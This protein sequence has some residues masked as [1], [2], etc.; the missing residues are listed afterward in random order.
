[1]IDAAE[2]VKKED[3]LLQIKRNREQEEKQKRLDEKRAAR[4]KEVEERT[5]REQEERAAR[6]RE[7][8]LAAEEKVKSN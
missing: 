2:L 8:F 7:K 6:L 4:Q 1:M 3:A 5:L